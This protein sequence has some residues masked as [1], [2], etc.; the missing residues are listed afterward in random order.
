[1]DA[2][3][4]NMVKVEDLVASP[5]ESGAAGGQPNAGRRGNCVSW[6]RFDPLTHAASCRWHSLILR[7]W[8]PVFAAL[9]LE[10]VIRD[11]NTPPF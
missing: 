11:H 7:R 9:S 6:F 4:P 5:G 3:H 1:V 8:N 10:S 2:Q